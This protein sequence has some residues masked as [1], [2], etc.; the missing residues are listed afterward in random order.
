MGPMAVKATM[1]KRQLVMKHMTRPPTS[2][3][4]L[5]NSVFSIVRSGSTIAWASA[6]MRDVSCPVLNADEGTS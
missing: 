2:S 6:V 4:T 3:M 5:A 1:D